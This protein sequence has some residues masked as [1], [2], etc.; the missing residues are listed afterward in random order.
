MHNL[1]LF[2]VNDFVCLGLVAK[3]KLWPVRNV[4]MLPF[5]LAAPASF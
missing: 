4:V 3:A 5:L 2:E 1:I